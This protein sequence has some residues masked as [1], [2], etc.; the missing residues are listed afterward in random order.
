MSTV[1]TA[2]SGIVNGVEGRNGSAAIDAA[3]LTFGFL[4]S[5]GPLGRVA[6]GIV[7]F[8]STIFGPLAQESSPGG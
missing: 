4:N 3:N 5:A 7:N 2:G 1:L 6:S 8:S